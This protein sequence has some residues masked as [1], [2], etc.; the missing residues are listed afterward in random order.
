MFSGNLV[1]TITQRCRPTIAAHFYFDAG[2]SES[3][4]SKIDRT[5]SLR[6]LRQKR[7]SS[8]HVQSTLQ[9]ASGCLQVVDL[10]GPQS[11]FSE[12]E[13]RTSQLFALQSWVLSCQNLYHARFESMPR[14]ARETRIIS[15]RNSLD[16]IM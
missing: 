8:G 5:F 14:S 15:S 7:R 12:Q 10:C 4:C 11:L 13:D 1:R 9:L 2:R 3:R 16:L 6:N